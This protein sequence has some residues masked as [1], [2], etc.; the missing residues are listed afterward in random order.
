MLFP[1]V[2]A[3]TAT[4]MLFPSVTGSTVKEICYFLQ[5]QRILQ[6]EFYFRQ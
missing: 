5:L 3:S 1:P 6:Q 2:T 4:G